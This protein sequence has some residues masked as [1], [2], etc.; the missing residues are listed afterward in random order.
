MDWNAEYVLRVS[1]QDCVCAHNARNN[2]AIT[3]SLANYVSENDL[4]SKYH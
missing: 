3:R 2:K 1:I 4:N